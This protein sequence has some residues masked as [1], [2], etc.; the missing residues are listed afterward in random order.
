[1]QNR[2]NYIYFLKSDK[3]FLL[4]IK[5]YNILNFFPGLWHDINCGYANK[6][7]CEKHNSSINSTLPSPLPP[8]GCPESWV[9][10]KNK[11][12]Q[13]ASSVNCVKQ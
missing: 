10:F 6:F 9:F 8:G 4:N 3:L 12:C 1:M 5:H 7:L 11:V 13:Q 2:E